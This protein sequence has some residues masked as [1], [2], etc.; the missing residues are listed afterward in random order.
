MKANQAADDLTQLVMTKVGAPEAVARRA[1]TSADYGARFDE[2]PARHRGVAHKLPR[3]LCGECDRNWPCPTVRP[4][5]S[6]YADRE[7]WREE[8]R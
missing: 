7:G 2:R 4:L 8:W 6:V 3:R 5:A 1:A